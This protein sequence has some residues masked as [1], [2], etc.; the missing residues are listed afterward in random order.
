ML[1]ERIWMLR[2]DTAVRVGLLTVPCT[3]TGRPGRAICGLT[4]AIPTVTCRAGAVAVRDPVV[5]DVSAA[6]VR[7]VG[8]A[9]P[10]V[11]AV[12]ALAPARA[13]GPAPMSA[14]KA[15]ARTRRRAS[16]GHA[17]LAGLWSRCVGH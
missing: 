5:R 9:G 13:A 17:V 12:A 1:D 10:E 2:P 4:E 3:V 6:D 16:L 15:Q 14:A 7:A 8:A 11:A